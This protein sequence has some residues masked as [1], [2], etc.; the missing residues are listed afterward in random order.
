MSYIEH[1]IRTSRDPRAPHDEVRDVNS[2][3]FREFSSGLNS[4]DMVLDREEIV[5]DLALLEHQR[6]TLSK[7]VV[8]NQSYYRSRYP[9]TDGYAGDRRANELQ[10]GHRAILTVSDLG[11]MGPA[12]HTKW[13]EQP[14]S[15]GG[16]EFLKFLVSNVDVLQAIVYTAVREGVP[17]FR[18]YR[19]DDDNPLGYR[20]VR[21][22]GQKLTKDDKGE[23][24]RLT[25]VIENSGTVEDPTERRYGVR[26][27]TFSGFCQALLA[28]SL[29]AD[30]CPF[31][32]ERAR[33]GSLLGWYNIPFETVRLAYESGYDGNQQ[34]V[35]VQVHP[36]EISA[37]IGFEKDELV[38]EVRNPRT[39]LYQYDYGASENE[40]LVKALTAYINAFQFHAARVDR[41]TMP[42]G[43]LTVYG[44]FGKRTLREF[45][46]KWNALCRGASRRW[47][48]P[49]LVAP[50]RTEGGAAYTPVDVSTG[51]MMEAK[52]VVFLVS[53]ACALHG[54]APEQICMESFSAK[55]S[56]L[57]G[58]DTAEKL[59]NG[60]DRGKIP[61]LNWLSEQVINPYIV[62]ALT[63][64]YALTWMGLYPD[65][66]D[67]LQQRQ[68]LTLTVD[69][70]RRNDGEDAH[71]DPELGAMPANNP[72]A[73]TFYTQKVLMEKQQAMGMGAGG[74]GGEDTG[75]P[76]SE[77]A[78]G[79]Q[80]QGVFGG[81]HGQGAPGQQGGDE[82]KPGGGGGGGQVVP[83]RGKQPM[84]KAKVP[85]RA[86]PLLVEI[87]R[88][89]GWPSDAD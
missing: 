64:K 10:T 45:Q 12:T 46:N 42:R 77:R 74:P 50:S 30:A 63:D 3:M 31:E 68:L 62:R 71:P 60:M 23:I 18:P 48:L 44:R 33:D 14:T 76:G 2:Q 61:R 24:D 52:W 28:D 16:F 39:G 83:F 69:E 73:A 89:D 11:V 67:R 29:T 82:G 75:L 5:H 26:R 81:P 78:P 36:D 32:L 9:I 59:D 84:T 8:L 86:R 56:R 35:G 51:E 34:I 80:Q 17:Y 49:V 19:E 20:F 25:R 66:E 4:R 47:N 55:A 87:S 40:A 58:N 37:M 54:M 85:G 79:Y 72:A 15:R 21:R 53:L 65:N 70:V 57:S 6:E 1:L 88:L 22:D 43:F 13:A 7:A 38:Y 41:N 27:R